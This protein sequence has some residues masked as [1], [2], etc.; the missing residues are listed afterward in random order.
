MSISACGSMKPAVRI[1][2]IVMI[3][4]SRANSEEIQMLRSPRRHLSGLP[5][6]A[7]AIQVLCMLTFPAR[8][9]HS[10]AANEAPACIDNIWGGFD[11]QPT[12]AQVASAERAGGVA[13]SSQEQRR[14]GQIVQQLDQ[15]L[16][17][18]AGAGP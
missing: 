2:N 16:L 15:T 6:F 3:I 17:D 14:E 5:A 7:A 11:H 8:T 9:A 18:G 10:Q 13:P 4:V 1:G 12:E